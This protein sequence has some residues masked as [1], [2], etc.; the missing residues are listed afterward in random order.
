MNATVFADWLNQAAELALSGPLQLFL[1]AA[2]L[3][4]A[5][6]AVMRIAGLVLVIAAIALAFGGISLGDLGA[7]ALDLCARLARAADAFVG[8]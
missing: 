2:V 5:F 7:V 1:V 4:L 6:K 8:A 3:V